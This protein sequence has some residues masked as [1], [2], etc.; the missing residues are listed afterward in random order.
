MVSAFIVGLAQALVGNQAE[1]EGLTI[2]DDLGF[3]LFTEL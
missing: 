1:G 2:A 3:L